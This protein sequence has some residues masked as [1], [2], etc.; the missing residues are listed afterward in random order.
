MGFYTHYEVEFHQSIDWDDDVTKN[1]LNVQFL[2][3]RDLDLPRVIVS[4]YSQNTIQ[5]ILHILKTLYSTPMQYRI[6]NTK[7]WIPFV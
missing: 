5:E 4:V 7:E 2:Y 6:Y 3:L 1:H